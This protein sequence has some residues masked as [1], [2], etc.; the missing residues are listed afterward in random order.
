MNFYLGPTVDE[1][2][3]LHYNKRRAALIA[4]S[5]NVLTRAR[6]R[7]ILE[8]I[9]PQV[10]PY[11]ATKQIIRKKDQKKLK[12]KNLFG[13]GTE[14]NLTDDEL[15]AECERSYINEM[16]ILDQTID[17]KDNIEKVDI[18]S[19]NKIKSKKSRKSECQEFSE[20][21]EITK[22]EVAKMSKNKSIKSAKNVEE[23]TDNLRKDSTSEAEVNDDN[24]SD[25]SEYIEKEETKT[26]RKGRKGNAYE[27][28]LKTMSD[29]IEIKKEETTKTSKKKSINSVENVEEIIEKVRK[30][31]MSKDVNMGGKKEKVEQIE[32]KTEKISKES[33]NPVEDK[34]EQPPKGKEGGR[35]G[36]KTKELKPVEDDQVQPKKGQK[37]GRKG[38]KTK[39]MK[40]LED[41]EKQ[42][43]ERKQA[44]RK[45][46]SN[47]NEIKP[48]KNSTASE[49][50]VEENK[51]LVKAGSKVNESVDSESDVEVKPKKVPEAIVLSDEEESDEC[52]IVPKK[53]EKIGNKGPRKGLKTKK[54]ESKITV[55]TVSKI[56]ESVNSGVKEKKGRK[57]GRKALENLS[58][59]VEQKLMLSESDSG[60][61]VIE[62][63]D[64][65]SKLVKKYGN[66]NKFV[67]SPERAGGRP[68]QRRRS[69]R[70]TGSFTLPKNVGLEN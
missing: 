55:K 46:R 37:V 43:K 47:N 22:D 52:E 36:R 58:L 62:I 41:K 1:T 42:P 65:T 16:E 17:R 4:S 9:S 11:N 32:L 7:K 57:M 44:T 19:K 63:D 10:D 13:K 48:N 59:N 23:I 8:P 2:S 25:E 60:S 69:I 5:P 53:D 15:I 3:P 54:D 45:G 21:I 24:V 26:G 29:L 61:E 28:E 6:G 68:K 30:G 38:R 34:D 67:T 40:A 14:R 49:L 39:E 20:L 50:E 51:I 12:T 70:L 27:N 35:K 33:E 18:V 56:N 66:S 64:E 31:R